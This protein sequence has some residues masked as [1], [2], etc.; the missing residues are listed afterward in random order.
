MPAAPLTPAQALLFGE[1]P[2]ALPEGLRYEVGFLSPAEEAALLRAIEALPLEPMR[3]KDY[4]ARREVLSYG[5][6][7]DFAAGR[8]D[9]APELA[10]ALHPLRARVAAWLGVPEAAL[11]H[12]LVAR[13][14]EGTPLGWHRDVP[15]FE[16]VVG[17]SLGGEALMHF[18]PWPP[19]EPRR[20]DVRKLLIAP[21]SIYLMRGPARWEWQHSVAPV[22][23]L[24]YSITF[25]TR[26]RKDP[27]RRVSDLSPP[28]NAP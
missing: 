16:D 26:R 9:D 25:R 18:R 7:Y 3:Y 20:A 1:D 13:Y 27:A 11:A 17:V 21:R 15:E 19:R 14:S 4:T 12:V 6:S 24:R 28:A 5:G 23:A 8:L 10:P 2:L 22:A